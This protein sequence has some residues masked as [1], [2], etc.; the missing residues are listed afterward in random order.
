MACSLAPGGSGTFPKMCSDNFYK[1]WQRFWLLTTV[2]KLSIS[3]VYGGPSYAS[4]GS[5][6]AQFLV[7]PR[8][9]FWKYQ[10]LLT[11]EPGYTFLLTKQSVYCRD[12]S[13]VESHYVKL[14]QA[15]GSSALWSQSS[16]SKPKKIR[17]KWKTLLFLVSLLYL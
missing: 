16:S 9:Y 13:N 7:F 12:A 15:R 2:T 4:V 14:N 17:E 5:L 3:D 10:I 8:S 6:W 11:E 1:K